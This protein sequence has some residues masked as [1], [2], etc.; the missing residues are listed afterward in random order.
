ME[1]IK[2]S[3]NIIIETNDCNMCYNTNICVVHDGSKDALV[4]ILKVLHDC[5]YSFFIK[6]VKSD[7]YL[8]SQ[9]VEYPRPNNYGN[10][11]QYLCFEGKEHRD[12]AYEYFV[13]AKMAERF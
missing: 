6:T 1:I 4:Y 2:T 3:E 8:R 7:E 13:L 5:E 10:V 11:Y 9:S 12:E